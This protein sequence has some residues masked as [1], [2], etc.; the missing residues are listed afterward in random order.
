M[1][2]E[3]L[4]PGGG[5][6]L[7]SGYIWSPFYEWMIAYDIR[8]KQV[9]GAWLGR[10]QCLMCDLIFSTTYNH[11]K[12]HTSNHT[13]RF[14]SSDH[15]PSEDPPLR[16]RAQ[17]LEAVEEEGQQPYGT[18]ATHHVLRTSPFIGSFSNCS[19]DF[20]H[21][22]SKWSVPLVLRIPSPVGQLQGDR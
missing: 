21:G 14:L 8:F 18:L 10:E 20:L 19:P 16:V 7:A 22:G 11:K 6:G 13:C 9:F 15:P 1:I 2:P 5:L 4:H 17:G 3:R 12:D